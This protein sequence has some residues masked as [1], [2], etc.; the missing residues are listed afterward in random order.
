MTPAQMGSHRASYINAIL[1]QSR[2][3]ARNPPCGACAADRP[4]L[5]PFP[6]CRRIQ[7]HFGGCCGNCKWR[8]HAARCTARNIESDDEDGDE[9]A[10]VLAAGAGADN[11]IVLD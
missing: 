9:Q 6:E 7:G 1:I 5:R 11:P 4:G 10:I 2:G 8:D 3:V